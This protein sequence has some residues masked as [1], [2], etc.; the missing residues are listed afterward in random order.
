M[1]K[2]PTYS[3]RE[4]EVLDSPDYYRIRVFQ[5]KTG[6]VE[7]VPFDAAE[8]LGRFQRIKE[9]GYRVGVYA[10]RKFGDEERLASITPAYLTALTEL[11]NGG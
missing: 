7:S 1:P 11:G 8:A 6:W 2:P 4:Q 10:A 5:Y 3:Q 9:M